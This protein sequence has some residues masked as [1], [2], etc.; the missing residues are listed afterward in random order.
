MAGTEFFATKKKGALWIDF[1]QLVDFDQLA[2]GELLSV[3]VNSG[4]KVEKKK[5]SLGYHRF[6]FGMLRYAFNH[7]YSHVSVRER[8]TEESRFRELSRSE[9]GMLKY[10]KEN[11]EP[12]HDFEAFRED[13]LIFSGNYVVMSRRGVLV[14]EGIS[15]KIKYEDKEGRDKFHKLVSSIFDYIV[16][17]M[18]KNRRLTSD[19]LFQ[20]LNNFSFGFLGAGIYEDFKMNYNPS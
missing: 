1:D 12:V 18:P 17:K 3:V 16:Y 6:L 5:R 19:Q 7:L 20:E 10:I 2:E 4:A 8:L 15:L 14:L 11:G 9:K 13:T